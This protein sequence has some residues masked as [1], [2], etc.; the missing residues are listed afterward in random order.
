MAFR[1]KRKEQVETSIRRIAQ[2]QIDKA[3]AEIDDPQLDRHETVHQV[4]KRCK[5]LRGLIRLVR[6]AMEETYQAENTFF[7]D[8]ARKLSYVRDAHSIIETFDALAKDFEKHVETSDFAP[9]REALV[10]RRGRVAEDEVGIDRQLQEFRTQMQAAQQRVDDWTLDDNGFDVVAAGLLKTYRR[11]QKAMER[12]YDEPVTDN[13]HQWRK[14]VKYHWYHARLLRSLWKPVM[15]AHRNAADE[16]ADLLGDE[17]DLAVLGA[18]L[19]Q[20]PEHFAEKDVIESFLALVDRRRLELREEARTLGRRLL[21]E[22]PK[23]LRRRLHCYWGVWRNGSLGARVELD[24]H[25]TA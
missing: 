13:F 25:A 4:R 8:A 22:K 20:D 6:P 11:A 15:R 12:A 1:I 18:T 7:R 24:A 10:E 14:R 17:H 3:I 16:L 21:A 19:L 2:E 9:I 5:K 23:H